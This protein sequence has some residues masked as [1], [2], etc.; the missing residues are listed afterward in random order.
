VTTALQR[1]A[2]DGRAVVAG[3]AR[4]TPEPGGTTVQSR[5]SWSARHP[6]WPITAM[7]V[8]WPL[9][10][11]LGIGTYVPV[12]FAIPCLT[13]MYRWRATGTRRVK[14][15]P[16]FGIWVLFL[17]VT[18]LGVFTL[19]LTAP[20]TE[21]TPTSNRIISWVF[22]TISYLAATV[23][24]LYAGNL[25]ERELPRR[26][27]AWQLGLLCIYTVAGG[28][29]GMVLPEV[30]ITSP[31]AL[32]VP[33]SVLNSNY[34]IAL[35]LHP[36]TSQIQNFLGY[37]EGRPSAPFTYTNM[38]G[39]SLAI[40]A[41]W[42]FVGWYCYGRRKQRIGAV[43]VLAL[44]IAPVVYSLNR[45]LW[46]GVGFTI[47]YLAVRLAVRGRMAM[48]GTLGG[49]LVLAAIIILVSPL[50]NLIGQR[51]EH[52]Q[53]NGGRSNHSL[54]ALQDGLASPVVGFGDTRH[55]TG[56]AT[57]IS[58]GRS[59]NCHNCG[60]GVIGGD[61][62]VQTLLICSGIVGTVL[63]CA[64]FGYGVWRYRRDPTPY[65]MAG[66]LV[67]LLGFIFMFV[68]IAVG[69]PLVFTMLAYALLWRNEPIWRAER[70][71]RSAGPTRRSQAPAPLGEAPGRRG[72][73]A[74][75]VV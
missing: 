41:P 50:G 7:L 69:P 25:T 28:L 27:L 3:E 44:A 39:E 60:E 66:V 62:Q 8:G 68:Y 12:L 22:R 36:S 20:G 38:W 9:W 19:S 67:L 32:L 14:I 23:I 4:G 70:K 57:S 17:I 35:M 65:G 59:S 43:V 16:A 73:T 13:A 49:V 61:G 40:L 75:P 74:R 47:V 54:L 55:Q 18:V 34:V 21:V 24:L 51:L 15:P 52:G 29:G 33:Q 31:F 5:D 72:I 1:T 45:G 58:V 71:R 37:A 2:H 6:A 26:R 10:W 53:S 64:F 48:L 46:I 63:Y 42:L 56:S 11:V 30:Q